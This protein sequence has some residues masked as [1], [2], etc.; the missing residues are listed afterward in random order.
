VR[1]PKPTVMCFSG[2]DPTGGAG[3][4]ADVETLFAL[5]CHATPII[6]CL[7]T[8]NTE[9]ALN[10]R[11]VDA[12]LMRDQALTV[13]G[14]MPVHAFKIGLLSAAESIMAIHAVISEH[15]DIPVV[16]DPV[17]AA[18]GG[19]EFSATDIRE[20]LRSLLVPMSTVLTPNLI[21]LTRLMP[22]SD[23]ADSAVTEL[24]STGCKHVLVTG[25]HD[26]TESVEN[27]LYSAGG[28]ISNQIWP[29]LSGSYHGS[30]CTLAAAISGYLSL[31]MEVKEAVRQ[32]QDFTWQSLKHSFCPGSGQ[33]I[34]D[35]AYWNRR[36]R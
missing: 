19:F 18:G 9:N 25:T 30:G 21:E 10:V 17:F 12:D 1:D 4:Q 35:R 31:G 28:E 6:T 8:Q 36:N 22:S 29:R 14:D 33:S 13:I 2:L 27:R 23:S 11:A 34:P 16:V 3:I 26:E 5:G 7:T 15:P 20:M 24:L 32:A